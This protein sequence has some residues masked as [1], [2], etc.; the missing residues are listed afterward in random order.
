M[1]MAI[2]VGTQLFSIVVKDRK[3]VLELVVCPL[4]LNGIFIQYHYYQ[5]GVGC[6]SRGKGNR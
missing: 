3:L 2:F 1:S 4:I 6:K 5:S